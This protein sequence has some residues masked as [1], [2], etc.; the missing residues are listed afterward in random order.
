[1]HR[2]ALEGGMNI[3]TSPK[4]PCTSPTQQLILEEMF[5]PFQAYRSHRQNPQKKPAC[6]C[7]RR[8]CP[9][10]LKKVHSAVS[11]AKRYHLA[12]LE[13]A[14]SSD[15]LISPPSLHVIDESEW[16]VTPPLHSFPTPLRPQEPPPRIASKTIPTI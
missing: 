7:P 16:V 14:L 9:I 15:V 11:G 13:T 12:H 4:V 3:G 2:E 8:T 10:C 1:M 6:F 5:R